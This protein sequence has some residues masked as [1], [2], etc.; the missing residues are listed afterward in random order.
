MSASHPGPKWGRAAILATVG[1]HSSMSCLSALRI[2]V[3][4]P[5]GSNEMRTVTELRAHY[6]RSFQAWVLLGEFQTHRSRTHN[7]TATYFDVFEPREAQSKL[8][9]FAGSGLEVQSLFAFHSNP[10]AP[11]KKKVPDDAP[12][13]R[14]LVQEPLSI[15]TRKN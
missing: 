1:F 11:I 12:S 6:W 14:I 13:C 5:S 8:G 15:T 4:I 7:L 2:K 3:G 9:R 10:M